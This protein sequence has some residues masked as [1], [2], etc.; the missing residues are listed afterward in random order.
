MV[1]RAATAFD[2]LLRQVDWLLPRTEQGEPIPDREY[3][4]VVRDVLAFLSKRM[5]ELHRERQAEKASFFEWLEGRLKCSIDE[6]AGKSAI[7]AYDEKLERAE[8][9]LTIIERNHPATTPLDVS[10]PEQYRMRNPQ[11][12]LIAE[13]HER[14]VTRLRPIRE[15][16]ELTDRL[17]DLIVYRLY[18][19]TPGEIELVEATGNVREPVRDSN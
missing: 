6:L 7:W 15:Q 18:G 10:P 1:D 5:T 14:S 2:D 13:G 19:L 9:L 16:I 17:I 8:Q 3:A 11:R 4:D 12:D